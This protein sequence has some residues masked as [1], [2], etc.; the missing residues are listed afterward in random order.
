M[1]GDPKSKKDLEDFPPLPGKHG[2]E[3]ASPPPTTQELLMQQIPILVLQ[4]Q[5]GA[6]L[7][8]QRQQT[9]EHRLL[10]DEL[11]RQSEINV[12]LEAKIAAKSGTSDSDGAAKSAEQLLERRRKLAY[13]PEASGNP[14]PPRPATLT[15][16]MPQLYDL[17][18]S[19]T[20]DALS[21]KSNS[22]MRYE[23]LVLAPALS[24]LHDVVCECNDSLDAADDGDLTVYQAADG[25]VAD[26]VLQQWLNDFDK[27]RGNAVLSTTAK[28]AANADSRSAREHRDQRWRERKKYDEDKDGKKSNGKGGASAEVI[29]W[30]TQGV[31]L[32]WKRSPPPQFDHGVSLRDA[33]LQQQ[34]WLDAEK[35]RLLENGLCQSVYLAVPAARLY[36]RELHFV[37]A[38]KS[39]WG[40]KKFIDVYDSER[41]LI[42]N[43]S[44][45]S[46]LT[47]EAED[48][49]DEN[50]K[51]GG[52]IKKNKRGGAVKNF[53]AQSLCERWK[54]ELGQSRL[55]NL[56]VE[57]QK[58]A[59]LD[60]TLD[61]Y[62]PKAERFI[63]FCVNNQRPWLPAT[64][65]TILLYIASMLND[66][67]V[68][69]TSLQPYLS[70]IN[71]YHEDLRFPG[72]AKGRAVTRAVKG[73]ATIQTELTMLDE[74]NIETQ[75]TWLP[76]RHVRRVHEAALALTP[77]SSEELL[78]LRAYVYVVIACVTFGRPD[79]V[80]LRRCGVWQVGKR[81]VVRLR[82]SG[83]ESRSG[84][85]SCR[86]VRAMVCAE[87][88]TRVLRIEDMDAHPVD[89]HDTGAGSPSSRSL[90]AS[91]TT[92]AAAQTPSPA[93]SPA[94]AQAELELSVELSAVG[95][96]LVGDTQE[97]L[98]AC[99]Q[100]L[101][102]RAAQTDVERKLDL[103]LADVQVANQLRPATY[104]VLLSAR[105]TKA[106]NARPSQT[107]TP[108]AL[109][110][111]RTPKGALSAHVEMLRRQVGGV[112]CVRSASVPAVNVT[113]LQDER[114]RQIVKCR[115]TMNAMLRRCPTL[116]PS[117]RHGAVTCGAWAYCIPMT[118]FQAG[119][120][121][122]DGHAMRPAFGW[123]RRVERQAPG[124]AA[125]SLCL[126]EALLEALPAFLHDL[127][128]TAASRKHDGPSQ[129][130]P[131]S[132]PTGHGT[133][134]RPTSH[135]PV[136]GAPAQKQPHQRGAAS[137]QEAKHGAG[138]RKMYIE[139]L[140]VEPI[141]LVVSFARLPFLP[142]GVK[143]L[144]EVEGAALQLAP[145]E[146]QH[147]TVSSS[148]LWATVS[149]HYIRS[150]LG[151]LYKLL[152]SASIFGDPR[153][154]LTGLW[155]ALG[156]LYSAPLAGLQE[157]RTRRRPRRT[158]SAS[159]GTGP[160]SR[161]SSQSLSEDGLA[162]DALGGSGSHVDSPGSLHGSINSSFFSRS[163][164]ISSHMSDAD[165]PHGQ[166]PSLACGAA[167][168]AW[169]QE[170]MREA[171][172][173]MPGRLGPEQVPGSSLLSAAVG[174]KNLVP[175]TLPALSSVLDRPPTPKQIVFDIDATPP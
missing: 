39:S 126:D 154:L 34:V 137:P 17:H 82:K 127:R 156:E 139:M 98:Y 50:G 91:A 9:E 72:P 142:A 143:P 16:R 133:G 171:H 58:K 46:E 95:C 122:C 165:S 152:G 103:W 131:R 36:L 105:V 25:L 94:P 93:A 80:E 81:A 163:S 83:R 71:N 63:Q 116:V 128:L 124:G 135:S 112:V 146:L 130:P 150:M 11:H 158:G 4:K 85:K 79:T 26:E 113:A 73:M 75:R 6:I 37:L 15:S 56:A 33:T 173:S 60:S 3:Q 8:M 52:D 99:I 155:A 174:I 170:A 123:T 78:L 31:K 27:N 22:S 18:G 30:I 1:S 29:Q 157:A 90:R 104:P 12:A 43:D 42:V 120:D 141:S 145:L 23:C 161:S 106:V 149:A 44:G 5:Q 119:V 19:K 84:I 59:L 66:G 134:G 41:G 74:E 166:P 169:L 125:R 54:G 2:N 35:E 97:L 100:G 108:L 86:N 62:G 69:A 28:N 87:G 140:R 24:Y 89:L 21:K 10:R 114:C 96:S 64:E 168:H 175:D 70:A 118:H 45:V 132:P 162:A 148:A 110:G 107:T 51:I 61:N 115:K 57:M 136:G 68:K 49:N 20:Y 172:K 102:V 55:T 153:A 167:N 129:Q 47:N 14:F 48:K 76:A 109:H 111:G 65:A 7:E 121:V 92:S 164:S 38:E 32:R 138:Q 13:V 101:D 159:T 160:L 144:V 117:W 77:R 151:E 67:G 147:P 53:L 40:A 88:P